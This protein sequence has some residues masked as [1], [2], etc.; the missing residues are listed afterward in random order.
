MRW[1]NSC[2]KKITIIWKTQEKNVRKLFSICDLSKLFLNNLPKYFVQRMLSPYKKWI[3]LSLS[4]LQYTFQSI[5]WEK[6]FNLYP[7]KLKKTK[8]LP[9]DFFIEQLILYLIIY[10]S[11]AEQLFRFFLHDFFQY[12]YCQNRFHLSVLNK[13]FFVKDGS[14]AII[15]YHICMEVLIHVLYKIEWFAHLIR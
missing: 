5:L 12:I 2:A 1:L 9:E 11:V 6:S 13:F 7:F 15:S 3:G 10:L 14:C 4:S 8:T